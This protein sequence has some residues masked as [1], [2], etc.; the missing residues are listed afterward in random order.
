MKMI[1]GVK[2]LILSVFTTFDYG[3]DVV[4]HIFNSNENNIL[5]FSHSPLTVYAIVF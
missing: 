1:T 4:M 3:E 2:I 5:L